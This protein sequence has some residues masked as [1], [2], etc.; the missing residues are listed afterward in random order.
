MLAAVTA[1]APPLPDRQ[2]Q[3]GTD[4][5]QEWEQTTLEMVLDAAES[6]ALGYMDG[7]PLVHHC[8]HYRDVAYIQTR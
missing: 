4:E 5:V 7:R 3:V 8:L 1:I 2:L 6:K